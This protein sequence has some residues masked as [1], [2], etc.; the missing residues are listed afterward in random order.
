[1]AEKGVT[2]DIFGWAPSVECD[3][4][5][6]FHDYGHYGKR[7]FEHV[8]GVRRAVDKNIQI[9]IWKLIGDVVSIR[10]FKRTC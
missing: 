7:G 8:Y 10:A 2:R 4:Y 6:A 9:G 1:H 5:I 3:G